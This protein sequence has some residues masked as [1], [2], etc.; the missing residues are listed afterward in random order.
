VAT[1]GTAAR[2]VARS[3]SWNA[4]QVDRSSAAN[5]EPSLAFVAKFFFGTDLREI[6]TSLAR[7]G[8]TPAAN[9]LR[10]QRAEACSA[11]LR[12]DANL[13]RPILRELRVWAAWLRREAHADQCHA[14]RGGKN[15][16]AKRD[17]ER[18]ERARRAAELLSKNSKLSW[19]EI[20][21]RIAIEEI[22]RRELQRLT[23]AKPEISSEELHR[24]LSDLIATG[25]YTDEIAKLAESIRKQLQRREKRLQN[26]K[27]PRS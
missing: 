24:Q 27:A 26:D 17:D 2:S 22:S 13:A 1:P 7:L 9:S 18:E 21:K 6:D 14:S 25:R 12:G 3:H 16:A 15:S 10:Q 19:R 20:G 8:S 4:L 23:Q 11:L 5:D